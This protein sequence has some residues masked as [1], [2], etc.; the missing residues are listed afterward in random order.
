MER[1]W[2]APRRARQAGAARAAGAALVVAML[3]PLAGWGAAP[4]QAATCPSSSGAAISNAPTPSGVDFV[5]RGHGWGHSLGLSQYGA[6]G[7]ARLGCTDTQILARYYPGTH[8]S[9]TALASAVDVKLVTTGTSVTVRAIS[10]SVPWRGDAAKA[11]TQ[12]L[13]STWSVV[14]SG[15]ASVL[16]DAAGQD[17]FTVPAGKTLRGV[18]NGRVVQVRSYS[19]ST[20]STDR[21]V[22]WD[23]TRF[24]ASSSGLYVTQAIRSSTQGSAVQKYLWGLAEVPASWPTHALRA[25]SIAART[26]LARRWDSTRQAYTVWATPADQNYGGYTQESADYQA[27]SHWKSAV[28]ATDGK[29]VLTS[30]NALI[31]ALYTSSH[32]GRSEDVRYSFGSAALS[33]LVSV[34]DSRWDLAS[35]N[36]YRSWAVG[37]SAASMASRFGLTSVTSVTVGA[38]GTSARLA[39]VTVVGTLNGSTVTRTYNGMQARSILGVRSPGFTIAR[40][41]QPVVSNGIPVSGDW[42]GD[43]RTDIGWF[44]DGVWSLRWPDGTTRTVS[45]GAAGDRPVVGDW[46]NNGSDGIGVFRD[47][48]WSLR[49]TIAGA[50]TPITFTYGQAHDLP[51]VGHW[52]GASADGIGVVRKGVWLMRSQPSAGPATLTAS[53]PGSGLPVMGDWDNNGLATPGWFGLG[54]WRLSNRMASP[55]VQKQLTFGRRGDLPVVGDWDANG[56]DTTGIARSSSFFWRNDLLGGKAT[57]A[58]VYQPK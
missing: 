23:E 50:E 51:V 7:A 12:P 3:V 4:A 36:P 14:F 57:G 30:S 44:K 28:N 27:G 58:R 53:F 26:Y 49:N 33:Y 24:V 20:L 35:D 39:G 22:R 19:G 10:A 1:N 21:T 47:G 9:A 29:V 43:G 37:Y 42:N 54:V 48:Q 52:T 25:Q 34:D 40:L 18:E 46:N 16:R 11:A 2:G 17:V 55:A 8:V 32:G 5:V 56:S 6:Q 31:D 13:G 15:G 41:T 38:P 45:L